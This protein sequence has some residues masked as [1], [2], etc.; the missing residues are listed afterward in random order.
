MH[1]KCS[2]TEDRFTTKMGDRM[3]SLGTVPFSPA[4]EW[5]QTIAQGASYT[6]INWPASTGYNYSVNWESFSPAVYI[7]SASDPLVQIRVP[8]TWGHPGGTIS[9]RMPTSASGAVG[10]DGELIVI[11]G[12]NVYNFWQL[13]RTSATTA[14]AAAYAWTDVV[15]GSG[16]GSSQPFLGAGT[17]AIGS[18]MLGGL[19][20]QAETDKGE[21]NHALQLVVD[22]ALV[23]PGFTGDAIA[24]DG[25]NPNGIVTEGDHLGI[26]PGTP[27]PSG[28]SELGQKVFRAMQNYGAYVVDVAGGVTVVR[29][30]AN[31]YDA[32]TMEALW[33]DMGKITPLLDRVT[34]GTIP[35]EVTPPTN[36]TNPTQQTVMSYIAVGGAGISNGDG[37]LNSGT[38]D[39]WL[40]FN[41]AVNVTGTPTITLNDGGTA[42]Y[43]SGSGTKDL[44]FQYEIGSG[45]T[46]SDLA[47]TSYNFGGVRD[48]AG[49]AINLTGAPMQPAG[50]LVIDSKPATLSSISASGSGITNGNGTLNSGT[51]RLTLA[52]DEAVK[53][54]GTS[55]S[56]TLNNGGV[57]K[58]VSG[59]GSKN[60]VFDYQIASGQ[61][62][63]DLA[64]TTFNL[65][66]V[67]D[68]AGNG[69]NLTNAPKNPAGT[70]VIGSPT[71]TDTRKPKLTAI[72]TS[73]NGI[74]NGNG[75]LGSGTVRLTLAFDEAV[76]VTGT[77]TLTLNGGGTAKYVSGSGTKNLV[78]NYEI[79]SGQNSTDLRVSKFNGLSGVTDLAGNTVDMT[80]APRN[81]VGTLVIDTQKPKL[82]SI[83]ASGTGITNGNGTVKSGTVRLTLAFSEA[84]K[85]DGTSA[86]LK[87]N[88]GGVANYVSG[89]GS[90]KLVFDYKVQSGQ[91]TSDL[92]VSSFNLGTV[93]DLA[94]NAL[95]LKNAPTNPAGTL[96][97]A[98]GSTLTRATGGEG[99]AAASLLALGAES[100]DLAD[101]GGGAQTTLAYKASNSNSVDSA[102]SGD[103]A[104]ASKLQL[105][106]QYA[107]SS[108]ASSASATGGTKINDSYSSSLT[109]TLTK[110]S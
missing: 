109:S 80:D 12:N 27:M 72:T 74:S 62:T 37:V 98:T 11:D 61:N 31:A 58:Y 19:L 24:G 70:L 92:A 78:F 76:K 45:R 23:K 2:G 26:P 102:A 17:T 65:N 54:D 64:V 50:T 6:N 77:P 107:A 52:F 39:I 8:A 36:P 67:K 60:L 48:A 22:Y 13:D 15:S 86:S 9:V 34:G 21:I 97:I 83:T 32:R 49:N 43:V 105:L 44:R 42:R 94:G 101:I 99:I 81:P 25:G 84:V 59:S 69:L 56:L 75:K 40:N 71:T 3:Y 53:V 100:M 79:G 104:L 30:Q 73:G 87:L 1:R 29:A 57:A 4:S 20:V 89:S 51:V 63:S 10:T 108:L 82:S 93:K 7:A 38:V 68:I 85:V 110:S 90:K 55:P 18:N 46:T 33:K 47:V 95:N 66:G 106:G 103:A 14:T 88:N 96:K 91:N 28:L 41:N 5:N 16:W 35:G